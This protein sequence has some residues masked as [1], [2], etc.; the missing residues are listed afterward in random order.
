M[1]GNSARLDA[2][3]LLLATNENDIL[4]RFF[5]TGVYARGTVRPTLSPAMDI[6]VASNFERYLYYRVGEDSDRTR[7]LMDTFARDGRICVEME[8]GR[9]V[10]SLFVSGACDTAG[11]LETIREGSALTLVGTR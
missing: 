10:D 4:T 9:A 11:T 3:R 2:R 6:Q 5:R 8:P 7:A 1:P